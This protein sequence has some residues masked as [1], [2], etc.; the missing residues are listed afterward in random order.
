MP[1]CNFDDGLQL[2][3]LEMFSEVGVRQS[4]Q[5]ARELAEGTYH[6]RAGEMNC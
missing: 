4:L 1:L 2:A 6:L 3:L 5:E